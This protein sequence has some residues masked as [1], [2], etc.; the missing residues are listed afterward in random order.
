MELI[1]K[2]LNSP[3]TEVF[4]KH[5]VLFAFNIASDNVSNKNPFIIVEGYMDV[6]IM[7]QFGFNTTIGTMGTALSEENLFNVWRYCDEPVICMD[8]DTAGY[9]AMIKIAHTALEKLVPGKSLKFVILQNKDDPDSYL[10]SHGK[11]SMQQLINNS[12]NLIDFLWD[13]F[14]KDFN[15]YNK[16]P[17]NIALWEKKIYD[18]INTIN[19]NRIKTFYKSYFRNKIYNLTRQLFYNN[20]SFINN[21][22]IINDNYTNNNLN[23]KLLLYI[24]IMRPFIIQ[25]VIEDLFRVSFSSISLNNIR[26]SIVD[27]V[28]INI[29]RTKQKYNTIVSNI[30][31]QCSKIYKIDKQT[32]E[33]LMEYWYYLLNRVAFVSQEKSEINNILN[34]CKNEVNNSNW[35]RLKALKMYLLLMK[36]K[37]KKLI[38]VTQ[39]KNKNLS[40][41]NTKINISKNNELNNNS[42]VFQDHKA[43]NNDSNIFQNDEIKNENTFE[44]NAEVNISKNNEINNNN[45]N[46]FQNDEITNENTFESNAEVNI[47]KNNGLNNN[48]SNIFQNNEIND[49]NTFKNS[50]KINI[51]SNNSAIN[52]GDLF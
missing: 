50:T 7:H 26:N 6:V 31:E 22:E 14:I 40:K 52:T 4:K 15:N 18:T 43:N 13:Y 3:E 46:I 47:S 11:E 45:S 12:F 37:S 17:E 36:N 25:F 10:K 34:D 39:E 41:N 16:T 8:G 21:S 28:E 35:Q 32:N 29:D 19:N 23:E 44:S 30:V 9:N 24:L 5:L 2:Y 49:K 1:P 38:N 20:N 33:E 48:N 51:S 42:N 27:D